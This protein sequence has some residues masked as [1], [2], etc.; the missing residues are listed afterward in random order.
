MNFPLLQRR[1]NAVV[2]GRGLCKDAGSPLLRLA[3]VLL[4]FLLADRVVCH[5]MQ[6]SAG[7]GHVAEQS[8]ILSCDVVL[9]A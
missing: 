5:R 2:V 6:D 9:L 1:R 3:G 7:C 8:D 4:V